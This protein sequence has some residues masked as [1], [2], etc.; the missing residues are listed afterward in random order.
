MPVSTVS[1]R[2]AVVARPPANLDP[3]NPGARASLEALLAE[4]AA[5]ANQLRKT[6]ALMPRQDNTP[7]GGWNI[8][9]TLGR[10]GPQTVPDIARTRALSRQNIQILVNRLKFQGYVA[11]TP[12][13]A[14]KLSGL[15]ELTDRGRGLLATVME[16]EATSLEGLLPYVSQARLAPAARLL[17]RLRELLAGK[18]LPLAETAEEGP[19]HK[20]ATMARK[21]ARRER[22][23]SATAELPA[24]PEPI[25]PDEAEFPVNLL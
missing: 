15:V 12:N 4:V 22:A 1:R 6:T 24:A 10:L 25:E 3:A 14:H 7:Q 16:R 23:A 17:R 20:P 9:Q 8:L 21:H 5:L 18:E 19:V 13:P 11:V 2:Q